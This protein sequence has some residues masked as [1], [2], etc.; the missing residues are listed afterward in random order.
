MI[1]S[2]LAGLTI[3]VVGDSHLGYPG[4]LIDTLQD[5]LL[6][7]GA[8]QVHTVGVCGS[9]PADW[10][11]A[12]P[13]TCGGAERIGKSPMVRKETISTT[14]ISQLLATD[15][16]DLVIVV[17]GDTMG[18]Y[19]KDVF[20][21]TWAWQQTTGLTKA[22]AANKTA[23]VWV[24]PPW[25]SPGGKYNKTFGRVQQVSSFLATNVAPCEYIDTTKMSKPGEWGSTDGQHLTTTAYKA[26]G[27]DI[28][29]A[30]VQLP[31]VKKLKQ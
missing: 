15:K 23:C 30:L 2:V 11:T 28:S 20:P 7:N 1:A 10:L 24:G 8:K 9:T 22:I 13:G 21:K 26:W 14:P 31:G 19:G 6:A 16:P 29:D 27:K 17:M 3:L 18:G 4:Y 5:N 25:G 12:T